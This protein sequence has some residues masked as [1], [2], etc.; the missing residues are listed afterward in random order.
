V[1]AVA[2]EIIIFFFVFL[3]LTSAF[4]SSDDGDK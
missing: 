3:S 1:H 4:T 2:E